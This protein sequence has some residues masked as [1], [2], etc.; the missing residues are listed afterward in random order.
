[1]TLSFET[2]LSSPSRDIVT[3]C[4]LTLSTSY[5]PSTLGLSF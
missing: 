4:D 3:V 2:V 1:M 5:G